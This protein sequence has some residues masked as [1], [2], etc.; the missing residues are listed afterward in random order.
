[1]FALA[2]AV[3]LTP[4]MLPMIVT[5]NL[6]KEAFKLSK[7]QT[8]VKNINSIQS[9][10]A[11]DVLC[12]DKTGTL[13]EDHIVLQRHINLQGKEDNRV[14]TYGY[15]NS[16]YQTGLKNLIDVAII[17]KAQSAGFDKSIFN[18]T[19]ID[20]IPFDFSR[21]RMSVILKDPAGQ[22]QLV[23]KGAIEEILSICTHAEYKGQVVDIDR[24]FKDKIRKTVNGLNSQGMRVIAIAIN[25]KPLPTNRQFNVSDESDMTLIGYIALLDPPKLSAKSA[26]KA[27]QEKGVEVKILTGDNDAVAKYV[28][29]SVGIDSHNVLLGSQIEDMNDEQ[30]KDVVMNVNVFA[31]LSPEQK[32]RVVLAIKANKHVVGFMG[33]GINDAPAMR[34]ADIGISVDTA[35]EIAKE[36]ADIVLLEKVLMILEKGVIEGR[37]SYINTMKYI[38]MT[39]SANFGN[40]LSMLVASL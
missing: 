19:K 33:D 8:I 25:S 17:E 4:E 32:S 20:E 15:L 3:G 26:I 18:F 37:K 14:L 34:A 10:G 36:S 2:I 29:T 21:R 16:Y 39:V 35:V 30:L 6:A 28:C 1:M 22:T 11:M 27:L 24:K 23:T 12:T 9:F 40:M 7:Q 38:K 31:K 5:L 13:T